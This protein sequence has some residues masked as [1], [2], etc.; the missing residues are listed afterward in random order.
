MSQSKIVHVA[1]SI[2]SILL[3]FIPDQAPGKTRLGRILLHPFRF[4]TPAVLKDRTKC[5][6]V[7]PSYAEPMA[8]HIFTFG[9]YERDTHNAILKILP[10]RGVFIDV[11]AN[12]GA[13]SIPI[14]RARPHVS[15]IC[16]EADP[17]IH[18]ILNENITRNGC[19]QIQ[20]VSC[21]CGPTDGQVVKFYPAPDENFG[22]GSLGPQFS[23]EPIMLE[24]H[25]LDTILAGTKVRE[26]DVIKIDVEGAEIGVLQGTRL[27]TSERSPAIIFEFA[28]WAEARIP[29]QQ[30]GDA[31]TLL[32]A[33]GYRLFHLGGSG[34]LGK[35]LSEPMSCGSAM[36]LA[37]PP[38]L[39]VPT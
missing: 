3:R 24:Q 29:G 6:Y 33:N 1:V 12:I 38:R 39:N 35:R 28:D 5:T 8:Q 37:F 26:V 21:V 31:Q 13:L 11:G 15:I 16:I 36:L 2:L 32:L 22:M 10:E 20:A 14:A 9:A 4:Q 25:S 17:R 27:L 34:R 30:A 18:R 7:L 23:N 19:S